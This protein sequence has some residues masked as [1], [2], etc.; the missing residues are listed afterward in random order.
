M[1]TERRNLLLLTASSLAALLMPTRARASSMQIFVKTLTGET[2]TLDVETDTTIASVKSK[3]QTD[4][5]IPA[6]EQRLIFAG[7]QLEDNKKLSDYNIQNESTLHLVRRLRGGSTDGSG[8]QIFVKTLTGE[9]F[10]LDVEINDTIASVKE[11][12]EDDEGYSP[13]KQRLIFAGKQLEDNKKL[14]DY[15]IQN[16]S[17]LHLVLRLRG[18]SSETEE[19]DE[20]GRKPRPSKRDGIRI[21]VRNA[22]GKTIKL[23]VAPK[24]SVKKLKARI[25]DLSWLPAELQRLSFKGKELADNRRLS[26]Y[27]VESDSTINLAV[28][29]CSEGKKKDRSKRSKLSRD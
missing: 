11:Q 28:R 20:S 3:I 24:I 18:G 29:S 26:D 25:E 27:K 23:R 1:K 7:R 5:G 14:A 16:E 8:M 6:S 17:T 12:I 22:K 2:F 4:E 10:T 9:T 13:S 21:T 19:T 15:N